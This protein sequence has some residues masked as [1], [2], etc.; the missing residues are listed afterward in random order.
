MDLFPILLFIVVICL[1]GRTI[2]N[3]KIPA[4]KEISGGLG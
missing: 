3:G 4:V 1:S 2:S